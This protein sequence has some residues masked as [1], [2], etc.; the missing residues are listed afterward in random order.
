MGTYKRYSC[1]YK[2]AGFMCL[3]AGLS[4]KKNNINVA[5]KNIA[6]FGISVSVFWAIGIICKSLN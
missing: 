6:D 3:E 4:R 2:Q 5:L 1:I